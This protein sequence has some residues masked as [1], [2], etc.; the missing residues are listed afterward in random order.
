MSSSSFKIDERDTGGLAMAFARI[1]Y[2]CGNGNVASD[3]IGRW[4]SKRPSWD[5][6]YRV[7]GEMLQAQGRPQDA[8]SAFNLARRLKQERDRQMLQMILDEARELLRA[9]LPE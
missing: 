6:P 9:R 1:D 7:L 3:T 5:E 2:S 4:L 8:A